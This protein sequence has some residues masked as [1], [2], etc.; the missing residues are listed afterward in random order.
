MGYI[1][2]HPETKDRVQSWSDASDVLRYAFTL[3]E[4]TTDHQYKVHTF[5]RCHLSDAIIE[6]LIQTYPPIT[7]ANF[8]FCESVIFISY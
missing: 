3:T 8:I 1:L 5:S 2:S 6:V 4:D 7:L